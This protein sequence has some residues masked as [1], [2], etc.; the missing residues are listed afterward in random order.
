MMMA[1]IPSNKNGQVQMARMPKIRPVIAL[2]EIVAFEKAR[3]CARTGWNVFRIV[4][5]LP[6]K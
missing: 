6:I 5:A 4:F 2:P 3:Y 1:T